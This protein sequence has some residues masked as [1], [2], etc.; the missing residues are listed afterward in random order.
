MRLPNWL[1]TCLANLMEDMARAM[2]LGLMIASTLTDSISTLMA[3]SMLG[4]SLVMIIG[5]MYMRRSPDPKKDESDP[6]N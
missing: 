5:A 1:R 3:G 6:K 4:F 2:F